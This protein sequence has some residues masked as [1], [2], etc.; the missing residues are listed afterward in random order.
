[1][2]TR[3]LI[4]IGIVIFT[5]SVISIFLAYNQEIKL[6]MGMQTDEKPSTHT[7][8]SDLELIGTLV[9]FGCS[10]LAINHLVSFSNLLD[11]EFDGTFFI[12]DIGLPYGLSGGDLDK[13]IDIAISIRESDYITTSDNLKNNFTGR[14]FDD[15]VPNCYSDKI[16]PV[17]G[18][19]VANETHTF[20]HET[21]EWNRNVSLRAPV[22]SIP[23]GTTQEDF[24]NQIPMD[25]IYIENPNNPGELI[26]NLDAILQVQR[27]L[28]Y[29]EFDRKLA[30]GE[31]PE[32][33]ADGSFNISDAIGLLYQNGTH[34]IDN[35]TC[36]WIR[37]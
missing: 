34:Y 9:E 21:C 33:N 35:N 2:K 11:E 28:K 12:N 1:M 23:F 24:E 15:N 14:Y 10:E 19:I 17:H 25:P 18:V 22:Y 37:K 7:L 5:V 13:C 27:I 8:E 31:I 36:E 16:D 4:I 26:L 29:C 6:I 20:N 32:R 3:L 30:S